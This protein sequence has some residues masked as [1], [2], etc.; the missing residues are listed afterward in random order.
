MNAALNHAGGTGNSVT[1]TDALS[2]AL[3]SM[4][5]LSKMLEKPEDTIAGLNRALE[6]AAG[7]SDDAAEALAR[8]KENL[9]EYI[10][11]QAERAKALADRLATARLIDQKTF[12]ELKKAGKI[13][14]AEASDLEPDSDSELLLVPSDDGSSAS[15]ISAQADGA[16]GSGGEAGGEAGQAGSGSSGGSQA[17]G[18]AGP[19]GG[20]ATLNFNRRTSEHNRDFIDQTLPPPAESALEQSV[21]IGMSISA[22]TLSVADE[23]ADNSG[24]SWQK[25]VGGSDESGIILPK[26]RN[27]VK[28]YFDHQTP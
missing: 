16:N 28:K 6:K 26:H 19:G 14:P 4:P 10:R 3:N 18:K 9:Q 25:P 7:Q 27:A 8:A 5:S 20:H 2:T 17:S 13:R 12:E 22:P 15:G 24:S 21:T 1:E 23:K 11:K